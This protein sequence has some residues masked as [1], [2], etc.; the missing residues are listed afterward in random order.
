[1]SN[2]C[3]FSKI[4]LITH[5][6]TLA[7]CLAEKPGDCPVPTTSCAVN[8]SSKP[9]CTSDKQCPGI[10]KCCTPKCG[11]ECTDPI[12]VKPGTCPVLETFAPCTAP[13][14][15]PLCQ[16]DINCPEEQ[17]CC[18]YGCERKCV[19]GAELSLH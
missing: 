15:L 3:P 1:L 6:K 8:P 13:F 11:Q 2:I 18:D 9:K 5:I 14:S 4:T 10:K 12:I 16:S 7:F 19:V 17:K